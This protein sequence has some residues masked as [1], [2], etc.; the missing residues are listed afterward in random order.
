MLFAQHLHFTKII[1]PLSTSVGAL[2][3]AKNECEEAIVEIDSNTNDR[4]ALAVEYSDIIGCIIDSANREGITPAMLKAA[5]S[6]KLDVNKGRKW[7][8]NGNGTYSHIKE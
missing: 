7:K 5:F 6:Y 1:F 2:E 8:Y 4:F 3:H